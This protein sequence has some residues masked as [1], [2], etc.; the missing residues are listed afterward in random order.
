M[1]QKKMQNKNNRLD[2]IRGSLIG[3]AVG[4]ALGYPVEFDNYSHIIHKYGMP[5]ITE[6][7]LTHSVAE[8]S[9][10]TQMTL[11]TAN[12][13]LMGLTR[14]YM[15]GIGAAP[16]HYVEYA[17][18][19]W[20]YTQTGTME[21]RINGEK[22]AYASR[23]TWLSAIPELYS[24]RAPGNTCMTAISEMI[25]GQTPQNNS[26]GCGGVMRIAPWPLFC[27]CHDVRYS[28]EEID[29][30]GGEIARLTHKH[31]LGWMPAI[32]L[33]DILYR[34]VKDQPLKGLSGVEAKCKFGLLVTESLSFIH[35]LKITEPLSDM[36]W[37]KD[38]TISEY[39]GKDW[40]TMLDLIFQAILLAD[41]HE[42]TDEERIRKLGQGWVAEEALAIAI[43]AVARHIDSFEDALIAAVNHDGDSDSTGAIAGNI[44][45]AIVGYDAIPNKFK[46]NL[47]LHDVIL[48]IADDLHQGCIISEDDEMDTPEKRQWYQRYCKM[49]PAGF[50]K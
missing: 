18:Q 8:I 32:L 4:D 9:D 13:L 15:R 10:D 5:G 7:E 41:E 35:N 1:K 29:V 14:K 34:L 26:K 21:S 20:F 40:F 33:T 44:I 22:E 30:A 11:F 28:V 47:E 49:Q 25:N 38:V 36:S 43:Y 2:L 19:D 46:K 39:F 42:G 3:G 48:A 6:Y 50:E 12:G 23:Y 27:A 31:P 24:R 16:H 37:S 17:Y 45:G